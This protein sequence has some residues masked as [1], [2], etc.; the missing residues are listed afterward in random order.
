[1]PLTELKGDGKGEVFGQTTTMIPLAVDGYDFAGFWGFLTEE[2][3]LG[4]LG[5]IQRDSVCTQVFLNELGPSGYSW[6]AKR[7]ENFK[8][9][10]NYPEEFKARVHALNGQRAVTNSTDTTNLILTPAV[11][12]APQVVRKETIEYTDESGMIAGAIIVWVLAAIFFIVALVTTLKNR[13]GGSMI[14]ARH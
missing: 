7:P 4:G 5:I 8:V 14:D 9:P 10:S 2:G 3:Y 13:G 6:T 11:E 1:M 12:T